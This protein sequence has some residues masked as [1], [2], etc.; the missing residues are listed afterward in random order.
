MADFTKIVLIEQ[1]KDILVQLW[2]YD[3]VGKHTPRDVKSRAEILKSTSEWAASALATTEGY[4]DKQL[5]RMLIDMYDVPSQSAAEAE[6][7]LHYIMSKL[8]P[9]GPGLTD[10]DK[11]SALESRAL[12]ITHKIEAEPS[13][14]QAKRNLAYL[15]QLT[16]VAARLAF[17]GNAKM[18]PTMDVMVCDF[19][20]ADEETVL[21]SIYQAIRRGNYP[22]LRSR[23]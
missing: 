8:A 3:E 19:E 23:M 1:I 14:D 10:Q 17:T 4:E 7:T 6:Q 11:M 13:F 18:S 5:N 16:S 20:H 22:R 9:D 15:N 2:L 12:T 21:R